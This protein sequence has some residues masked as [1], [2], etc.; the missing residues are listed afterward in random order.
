MAEV[1]GLEGEQAKVEF[2]V[3][4]LIDAETTSS[5]QT[6]STS[7]TQQQPPTALVSGFHFSR[8]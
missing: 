6:E 1:A 3:G 5:K 4:R 7:S 8:T 2:L